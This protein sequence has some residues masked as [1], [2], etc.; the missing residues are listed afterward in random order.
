MISW[1]S[2]EIQLTKEYFRAVELMKDSSAPDKEAGGRGDRA[3]NGNFICKPLNIWVL[4]EIRHRGGAVR[5][6]KADL[7]FKPLK[8]CAELTDLVMRF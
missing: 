4:I 3:A 6:Y 5:I 2:I 1:L 8:G 7:S